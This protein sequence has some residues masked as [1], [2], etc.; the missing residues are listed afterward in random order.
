MFLYST[1]SKQ[2]HPASYSVGNV[3]YFPGG[4]EEIGVV[5]LSTH[6]HLVPGLRLVELYLHSPIYLHG[7]LLN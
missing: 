4:G 2:A 3:V 5:N 1:A 7:I 6:L